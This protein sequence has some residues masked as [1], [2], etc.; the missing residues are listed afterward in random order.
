M[1]LFYLW[2][3]THTYTLKHT[4]T[5]IYTRECLLSIYIQ[6]QWSVCVCVCLIFMVVHADVTTEVKRSSR[7]SAVVTL[8]AFVTGFVVIVLVFAVLVID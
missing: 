7:F 5:H 4:H 1:E 8:I 2:T 6:Q 3:H